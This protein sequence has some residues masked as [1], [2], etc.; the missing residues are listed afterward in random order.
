MTSPDQASRR[1]QTAI[2]RLARVLTEILAPSVVVALLPLAL[3]WVVT[4][5]PLSTLGWG[6]LIALTSSILPMAVIVWGAR[7][8]R[9]D[10]HHVRNRR[11]RLIPLLA[12]I[13]FSII[14][15]GLLVVLRAPWPLI[16]LDLTLLAT[17]FITSAITLAWKVSIHAAVCMS[18][19]AIMASAG[20]PEWWGATLLVGAVAWSRVHLHDHTVA[21]VIVG[22]LT[23][24][25]AGGMFSLLTL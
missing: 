4:R 5:S 14:G 13:G 1:N 16:A 10:G 11:G 9:W 25:L 6:L 17:L 23:G 15:L 2:D 21:Q 20:G 18:A 12:T 22:A 7:A 8:G 3:A 24:L 19:V